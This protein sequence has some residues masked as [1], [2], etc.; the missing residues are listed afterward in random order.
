VALVK[1]LISLL[2]NSAE[3]LGQIGD[4]A[5]WPSGQHMPGGVSIS[6][7]APRAQAVTARPSGFVLLY[8]CEPR[9]HR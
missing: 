6:G 4:W 5:V 9:E 1:K 7:V 3:L 8:S 2:D